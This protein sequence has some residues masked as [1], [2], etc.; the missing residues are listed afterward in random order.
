MFVGR[1]MSKQEMPL[2]HR[3]LGNRRSAGGK[4]QQGVFHHYIIRLQK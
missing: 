4:I 3:K 1:N 2:W